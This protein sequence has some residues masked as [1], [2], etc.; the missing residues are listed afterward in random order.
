MGDLNRAPDPDHG[1][2][3]VP[4]TTSTQF[5]FSIQNVRSLNISTRNDITLQKIIAICSLNTDFIFLSDLRLNSLKQ[6]SAINDL[7]KRFFLKGYEFFHNSTRPSRGTGILIRKKIRDSNFRILSEVC[8]LDGNF[9]IMHIEKNNSRFVL[10]SIYGPNHDD[11]IEFYTHLKTELEKFSDPLY[12]GGDWNATLDRSRVGTNIDVL[13]MVNIPSLVRSNAINDLCT[14]LNLIDPYRALY[15]NKKEYT[16]IP[17]ARNN[18]NR[19]RLDFFLITNSLF[20]AK[21]ECT[22]PHNLTSVLFDHKPVK[23]QF[24]KKRIYRKE[25]IKDVILKNIDLPQQVR[26]AV[27]ECYLVHRDPDPTIHGHEN[28]NL[29]QQCLDNLGQID[30]LL[31]DIQNREILLIE[32]GSDP[33]NDVTLAAW[34]A[35]VNLRFDEM[36]PLEFFE[37]LP[38]SVTPDLLLQTLTCCIKNRVLSHQS[39]VFK[40]KAARKRQLSD[41]ISQLKL[42]FDQNCTSILETERLLS[43]VVEYELK[44]ELSFYKNFECLNSEKITP[45]FM[46]LVKNSGTDEKLSDICDNNGIPFVNDVSRKEFITDFFKKIYKKDE[47]SGTATVDDI[48]NFLG[49]VANHGTVLD[50]KLTENEKTLLESDIT[51]EELCKSINEANMS[52]APGADGV[53]NRFIKKFWDYFKNP[54]LKLCTY[55]YDKGELPAYFRSANIKLIPKKGNCKYT[56]DNFVKAV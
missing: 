15:P 50:S 54:L 44:E 7:K 1:P 24:C 46:N 53:S 29:V 41:R 17:S 3:P 12:I 27:Y 36:P 30:R 10:A 42:N 37:N 9:Y 56:R 4:F 47:N 5:T 25:V 8:D 48:I 20:D 22:V 39:F 13:N 55:C 34:R 28:P 14:S 33:D 16:F 35:D 18:V 26:F 49:P 45:H 6:I 51:L 52:S 21:T 32:G 19:S 38:T 40:K 31:R 23:L 43:D 2:D 11:E